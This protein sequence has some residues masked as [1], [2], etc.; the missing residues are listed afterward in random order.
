MIFLKKESYSLKTMIKHSVSKDELV[1]IAED[2]ACGTVSFH[3]R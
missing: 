1:R 3:N 2:V